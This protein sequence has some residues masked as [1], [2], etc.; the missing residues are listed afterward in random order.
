MKKLIVSL[1]VL[2][3]IF[4]MV[5]TT[6][7][8]T[9]DNHAV[10]VTVEPIDMILVGADVDIT[11]DS[12]DFVEGEAT[13]SDT[14]VSTIAYTTNQD[15]R[16]ITVYID[17]VGTFSTL[18]VVA[19]GMSGDGGSGGEVQLENAVLELNAKDLITLISKAAVSSLIGVL[20]YTAVH[21]VSN[22][23]GIDTYTVYYTITGP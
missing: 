18:K 17:A 21:D 10:T 13:G 16:K 2:S 4:G 12:T 19:S 20:T 3:L 9:T 6:M 5:G 23:I 15:G 8:G 7:A 1:A 14:R 11:I 22:G